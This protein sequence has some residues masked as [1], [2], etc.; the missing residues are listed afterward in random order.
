MNVD[1]D[2][3]SNRPTLFVVQDRRARRHRRF[4][5]EHCRQDLVVDLEQA[6]GGFRG[7]FGFGH[8][9]RH[10]LADEADDIVEHV[11]VVGV[12]EVILMRG[13]ASRAGAARPPR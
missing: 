2:V 1:I 9:G 12:D 7:A 3:V 6:A 4:R 8:D 13:G 5:V 10:A 11:G